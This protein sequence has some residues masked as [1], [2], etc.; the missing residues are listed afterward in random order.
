MV[1]I[2]PDFLLGIGVKDVNTIHRVIEK[3]KDRAVFQDQKFYLKKIDDV[4][5]KVR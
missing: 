5:G 1:H 4:T 2:E 3:S